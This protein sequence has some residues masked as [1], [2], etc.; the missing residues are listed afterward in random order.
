M[1]SH[2]YDP[3]AWVS[4]WPTDI[5]IWDAHSEVHC[6]FG[7][8]AQKCSELETGLAMLIGQMQQ[9]IKRQPQFAALLSELTKTALPL[10]PLIDLF[11]RLYGIGEDD[12]LA[13]ELENAKKARNYLIHHFYRDRADLFTTPEGCKKLTDML[14]SIHDDLDAARQYLEDWRDKHLGHSPPEDIW[15]RINADVDLWKS[16]NQQMLDALLGKNQRWG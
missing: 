7:V 11:C 5:P 15:D 3:Y 9:A 2:E 12:D 10:G 8:A 14:V 1:S 16:E 4:N 6:R 13:Q